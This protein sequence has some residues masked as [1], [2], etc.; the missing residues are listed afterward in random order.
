MH[1]KVIVKIENEV[2]IGKTEKKKERKKQ[3]RNNLFQVHTKCG[4]WGG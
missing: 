4:W 3:I 1:S 2:K